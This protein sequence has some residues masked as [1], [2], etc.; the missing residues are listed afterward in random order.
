[1]RTISAVDLD[2]KE[3]LHVARYVFL[4]EIT[5]DI[6]K[7]KEL[8]QEYKVKIYGYFSDDELI[9]LESTLARF[10]DRFMEGMTFILIPLDSA[11]LSGDLLDPYTEKGDVVTAFYLGARA[12]GKDYAPG[13]VT[14]LH[15]NIKKYSG[16]TSR[17][18]MIDQQ[19][20]LYTHEMGH[21]VQDVVMIESGVDP[22]DTFTT[23]PEGSFLS[24]W[25]KVWVEKRDDPNGPLTLYGSTLAHEGLAEFSVAYFKNYEVVINAPRFKDFVDVFQKHGVYPRG[26][27]E[28]NNIPN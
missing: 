5:R 2:E 9:A 24:D 3:N 26:I 7:A 21:R 6:P 28:K 4:R 25:I 16:S 8:E 10:P 20:N 23:Y 17:S 18:F 12:K 11:I 13:S 27:E 14:I 15:N 22:E 1:M 19:S